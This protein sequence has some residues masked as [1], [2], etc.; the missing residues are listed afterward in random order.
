MYVP[1][2][3][4]CTCRPH[5]SPSRP[6]VPHRLLKL[7]TVLLLRVQLLLTGL[8]LLRVVRVM[9]LLRVLLLP[10]LLLVMPS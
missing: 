9:Q 3:C 8:L 2:G 7:L 4:L 10:L 1:A 5:K 6:K